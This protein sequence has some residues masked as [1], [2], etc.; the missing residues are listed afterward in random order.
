MRIRK[1]VSRSLLRFTVLFTFLL[2][3]LTINF[4]HTD[5][6]ITSFHPKQDTHTHAPPQTQKS[7]RDCPACHFLNSSFSTGRIPLFLLP[8]PPISSE[9]PRIETVC[10]RQSFSVHPT[11]RSPPAA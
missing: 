8:P 7:D 1:E 11:S 3:T 10:H 2:I 4:L 5:T 9:L 6:I